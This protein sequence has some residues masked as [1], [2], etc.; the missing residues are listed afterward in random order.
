MYSDFYVICVT[1]V[2]RENAI[3]EELLLSIWR[4]T[5]AKWKGSC[6]APLSSIL[7]PEGPPVSSCSWVIHVTYPK[8]NCL[9]CKISGNWTKHTL[10]SL[11]RD[12]SSL[13]N[14]ALQLTFQRLL[15]KVQVSLQ[16]EQVFVLFL[17]KIREERRRV[18]HIAT[19]KVNVS[20]WKFSIFPAETNLDPNRIW[21]IVKK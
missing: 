4:D 7:G 8:L 18:W 15:K 19:I 16:L 6:L 2:F 17:K 11:L 3:W 5:E 1:K 9:F 14:N 12:F 13:R 20:K 10:R 21:K